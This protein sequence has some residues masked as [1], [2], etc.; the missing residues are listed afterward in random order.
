MPESECT[1]I[2]VHFHFHLHLQISISTEFWRGLGFT[3]RTGYLRPAPREGASP[4]Q[5]SGRFSDA[6]V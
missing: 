5:G 4:A 3:S 1:T 2:D 6:K